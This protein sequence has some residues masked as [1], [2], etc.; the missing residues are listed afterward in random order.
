MTNYIHK[1]CFFLFLLFAD[2]LISRSSSGICTILKLVNQSCFRKYSG[3]NERLEVLGEFSTG[4]ATEWLLVFWWGLGMVQW[5]K[6]LGNPWP[7]VAWGR[8]PMDVHPGYGDEVFYS[9]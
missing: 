6:G 5:E 8:G 1:V 4:F 3:Q 2:V 7:L 9:F